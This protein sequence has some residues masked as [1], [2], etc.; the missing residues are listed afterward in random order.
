MRSPGGTAWR[1]WTRRQQTL[2]G[3]RVRLHRHRRR[4]RGQRGRGPPERGPRH[5][6]PGPGGR[7]ARR[8][9]RDRHAGRHPHLVEW[10]ADL[11]QRHGPAAAGRPAGDPLAER[12]DAGGQLVDQRHDLHPRQ[13]ARLRRLARRLRLRRL[14]LC[15]PAALLPPS[16]GPAA[17]R[18]GLARH[19]WAAAGGGPALRAPPQPGLAGGGRRL[20]PARQRGLQRRPPGRRRALPDD[21][22]RGAAL[23]GR[24]R[25]PAAGHGP[26]QPHRGDRRPCDPAAPGG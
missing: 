21:P 11:G 1:Q 6:R 16:R 15:R 24:R 10:A 25:L 23:V 19:R 13:P 8:P 12:A 7:T 3:A 20:G 4:E 9:S 18:V 22:A 14:G 17:G 2:G 5:P 26:A